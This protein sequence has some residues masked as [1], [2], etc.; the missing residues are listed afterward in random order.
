SGL[1]NVPGASTVYGAD[2]SAADNSVFVSSNG[3]VGIGTTVP[4]GGLDVYNK[5]LVIRDTNHVFSTPRPSVSA[6]NTVGNYEIRHFSGNTFA[7]AGLLRLRAGGGT[8]TDS[9]TYIDLSG[10]S[11]VP[12]MDDTIVFGTQ[13]TE[14]MRIQHGYVGIGTTSPQAPLHVEGSL[15]SY[16]AY[17]DYVA[18]FKGTDGHPA[19]AIDSSADDKSTTFRLMKNGTLKWGLLN[20]AAS[21]SFRVF[22]YNLDQAVMT[23]SSNGNVAI[24]STMPRA[25]LYVED[26]LTNYTE[27][28]ND[29]AGAF[30]LTKHTA[31]TDGTYN[32]AKGLYA[33]VRPEVNTGVTDSGA[34]Y[35]ALVQGLR[36]VGADVIDDNGKLATLIG[37]AIGYGHFNSTASEPS[38]NQAM[39]LSV[40][41]YQRSGSIDKAYDLFL[42][43]PNT[44]TGE[45]VNHFGIYQEN[46]ADNYFHGSVGIGTTN[47]ADNLDVD[48][49]I[50]VTNPEDATEHLKLHYYDAYDA[51]RIY[52]YDDEVGYKNTVIEADG[53][54]NQL[55]VA[56]NGS[57]GI[58]KTS[59]ATKLEVV[60]TVS[61][62]AFVGDGSGLT[63][64]PGAS[65]VYGADASAADDSV[66]VSANGHVGVG[67]T[68]P[69]SRL[70]IG[71]TGGSAAAGLRLGDTNGTAY[72]NIFHVSGDGTYIQ[73]QRT[74]ASNLYLGHN[75]LPQIM[76]ISGTAGNVGIGTSA[77]TEKLD[78][79][80][81]LAF[82]GNQTSK[83]FISDT[84]SA[85]DK[86]VFVNPASDSDL[87]TLL[88]DGNVG[89]GTT[90]PEQK[91]HI[92]AADDNV[93]LLIENTE[94]S[95]AKYPSVL[96]SN[97][98]GLGSSALVLYD[99][100]GTKA[101]P[102]ALSNNDII[103][104]LAFR[105]YDGSSYK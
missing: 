84:G 53:N 7:N 35:G 49:R 46:T 82:S 66:F 18:V 44:G 64:V 31:T 65:T 33:I 54:G 2:A 79:N 70:F 39:G 80:G 91:L 10:Y 103:G 38:T 60:G 9:A 51:G 98:G 62:N 105:A 104:L 1:T 78:I 30:F 40:T 63:N 22:S 88:D 20:Q 99:A 71:S 81:N 15:G 56:A 41:A 47:P 3:F 95:V 4:R 8:D 87:L 86:L 89:I 94:S 93:E 57:V 48:G 29:R 32:Y 72:T 74:D 28:T 50:A 6:G 12:D 23:I 96:V 75:V 85:G 36:N 16:G 67:S 73:N 58:G 92:A 101:S 42:A 68:N 24:G 102:S 14:D 52:S 55:V 76:T 97:Y 21:D 100:N 90:D 43:N 13:G 26:S 34:H 17:N 27:D 11:Q 77:P 19:V 69:V 45:I 37:T 61:A 5:G 25:K 83:I 59:P